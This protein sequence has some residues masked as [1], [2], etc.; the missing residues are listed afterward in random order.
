M[1]D[2]SSKIKAEE[3]NEAV[4]E[5][6][7]A[8]VIDIKDAKI[9][10]LEEEIVKLKDNWVRAVA[11]TDNVQKRSAKELEE[12]RKYAITAFAGDMVSVLENLKR[13]SDSFTA[14]AISENPLIKTLSDGVSL[15]LQELLG[16][17]QKYKIERI[18]PIGQKFNHNFHQ[19]VVQVEDNNVEVGTI[20]QVVQSGY[21]I[22]D[23]LLR[24]A[25]VVVSKASGESAN[26]VDTTA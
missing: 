6:E 16:I 25:M 26:K 4:T 8:E 9:A 20:M 23:R 18:D 22:A 15:T 1:N 7:V 5:T 12:L 19:A 24:P 2:E 13:A 17:F 14:E 11:E 21:I 3:I 10:Q